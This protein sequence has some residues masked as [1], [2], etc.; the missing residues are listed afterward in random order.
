MKAFRSFPTGWLLVTGL[1]VGLH[2]LHAQPAVPPAQY[3]A[4]SPAFNFSTDSLWLQIIGITNGVASLTLN[5]ATDQVYEVLS[6][7]DLT[8]TNWT[9]EPGEVWPTNSTVMPFTIL[10]LD[11]TKALF[12]RAAD[13]TGVTENGNTVPDWWFWKYFGTVALSDTNLDTVGNTLLYDYQNGMDP[14]NA[15]DPYN[16]RLPELEIISGNNQ[17]G[18]PGSFLPLPLT[19]RVTDS[20]SHT[21]ANAPITLSVSDYAQLA[22]T[23]NNALEN[24]LRLRTDSNGLASARVYIPTGSLPGKLEI[25]VWVLAQSGSNSVQTNFTEFVEFTGGVTPML[26]VGGERIMELFPTGDLVSW[27]GNQ[28]GELGDYTYL[29]STNPVHVVGLTNLIKIVSGLNHSL[30][31]DSHG[32]VRA[33]GENGSGEL[34]DGVSEDFTNRPE[35]VPGITSAIAIAAHGYIVNGDPGLSLAV[36]ADGTVWAWGTGNGYWV[37][38]SPVQIAGASNMINVAAGAGHALALKE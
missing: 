33:W 30:A 24:R 38:P 28:H 27:G 13:W 1:V 11:R 8:R 19:A 37:G 25:F 16:G 26:A 5:N 14:L 7:T 15:N 35:Q 18:F 36:E 6:K 3:G 20:N 10:V 9:I 22:T 34:G 17:S 21:L 2:F 12:I 4:A 29:D 31:L 32:V 23:T